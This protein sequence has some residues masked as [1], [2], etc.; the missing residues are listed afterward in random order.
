[1]LATL[2]RETIVE[3]SREE[4]LG[5]TSLDLNLIKIDVRADLIR[6]ARQK[7]MARDV[8]VQAQTKSGKPLVLVISS[9]NV[10]LGEEPCT[11]TTMLDITERKEAE[12]ALQKINT[13][14]DKRVAERTEEL[15]NMVF[16]MSGREVRMAELKKVIT[17]LREQL[18][19]EGITPSAYDPLLG[20]DEEW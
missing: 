7:E 5:F 20:P 17:K 11:I 12:D 13:E 4:V 6:K 16:L 3:Y 15:N 19:E 10:E 1:L 14:L 9:E 2:N 8:E 18:K